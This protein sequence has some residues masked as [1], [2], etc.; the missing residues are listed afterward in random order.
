MNI[1]IAIPAYNEE[2]ILKASMCALRDFCRSN[3][4]K[5]K[6][7]IVVADNNS[8]DDTGKLGREL[9]EQ[10]DKIE[11]LHVQEKGKGRAIRAVWNAHVADVYLFMDADL[12]TDLKALPL[13]IKE[14]E[15]GEDVVIGSR[16]LKQSNI[17]RSVA[18]KITSFCYR[19][20]LKI[21]LHTK[22]TDA[23]CGFKGV[24][25]KVKKDL[26]SSIS[27]NGWFFDSEL[28]LLAEHKGYKIKE[29]PVTWNDPRE[30]E[31]KSRV[32]TIKLSVEYYKK[33]IELRK[34]IKNTYL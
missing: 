34:R 3:I 24:S 5:H 29:I 12:A 2:Q 13:M 30:G 7:T 22:I 11:Y 28:V 18:R 17:S 6:W 10:Y 25:Q 31:D 19:V 23:P 14:F 9:E 27:D 16:A 32:N 1:V 21:A 4:S 26:L 20:L 33:V 8:T 15:Y